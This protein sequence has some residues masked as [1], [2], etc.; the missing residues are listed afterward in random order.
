MSNIILIYK[1][2]VLAYKTQLVSLIELITINVNKKVKIT[3][4]NSA[5]TYITKGVLVLNR[6]SLKVE[7]LPLTGDIT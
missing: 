3:I 4:L 1:Y 2:N 6:L 5:L 7:T